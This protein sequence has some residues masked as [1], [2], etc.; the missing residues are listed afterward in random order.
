MGLS[1]VLCDIQ[2]VVQFFHVISHTLFHPYTFITAVKESNCTF[3]FVP[4]FYLSTDT[5]LLSIFFIRILPKK[6][7]NSDFLFVYLVKVSS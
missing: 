4:L 5:Y 1:P 3:T 2:H 6:H 7:L